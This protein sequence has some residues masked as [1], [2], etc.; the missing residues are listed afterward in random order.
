MSAHTVLSG[1]QKMGM[2]AV[3]AAA[4]CA[5]LANPLVT[6]QLLVGLATMFYGLALGYRLLLVRRGM[7]GE[8]TVRVSDAEGAGHT[9]RARSLPV[10][11]VLVPAYRE[12]EVVG[13][14]I[15]AIGRPRLP[16]EKLDVLL[17]LEAD[18][19]ETIAA[20]GV[21]RTAEH[22]V[23]LVP[24]GRAAD[25]AEGVQLRPALRT[26]RL[27]T[28]YDAEDLPEPLQLRRAVV[29]F[30]RPATT[31]HACRPSSTTSTASRTTH[32]L[33]HRSSTQLVR[34]HAARAGRGSTLP[35]PLGRHQSTTSAP[36]RCATLGAWD[37][38]NVTEDADLGSALRRAPATRVGVVDS[39]T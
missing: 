6:A 37:P 11:T 15:G 20:P 2:A 28:I 23:V 33:V 22:P 30:R 8:N 39:T 17:L 24:A 7:R 4:V 26:R 3:G 1:R 34:L 16:G 9:P 18:D 29:A 35:I 12:P 5:I 21:T 38:F 13:D 10:Y 32:P 25:Q 27:V 19:D 31:S 36:T 14:L